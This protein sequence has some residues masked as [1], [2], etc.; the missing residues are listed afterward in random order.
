MASA[1]ES[2]PLLCLS[3]LLHS[4]LSTRPLQQEQ[5]VAAP[6]PAPALPSCQLKSSGRPAERGACP[7]MCKRTTSETITG[8]SGRIGIGPCTRGVLTH[9]FSC[10]CTST[11]FPSP[12]GAE[13]VEFGHAGSS[14]SASRFETAVPSVRSNLARQ[15]LRT[16][17]PLAPLRYLSSS[18]SIRRR[19]LSL[20][21]C[22]RLLTVDFRLSLNNPAHCGVW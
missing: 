2:E 22:F 3:R 16:S 6:L 13:L 7:S 11:R 10:G 18:P 17:A 9:L 19:V 4:P 1:S 8:R 12:L 5:G 20:H 15:S 14:S 21:R